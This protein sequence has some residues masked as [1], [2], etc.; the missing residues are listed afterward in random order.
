[1]IQKCFVDYYLF[2]ETLRNTSSKEYH[3]FFMDH[4]FFGNLNVTIN[5]NFNKERHF[6]QSFSFKAHSVEKKWKIMV[7]K[8]F[9]Y[10]T[11]NRVS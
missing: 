11:P 4:L 10:K 6:L 1:M 9:L 8:N 5:I 7:K 2:K 3:C